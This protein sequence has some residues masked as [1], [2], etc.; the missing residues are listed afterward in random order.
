MLMKVY[1]FT[2]T[3]PPVLTDPSNIAAGSRACPIET[4]HAY[5]P[6]DNNISTNNTPMFVWSAV[7]NTTVYELEVSTS[8]L[9]ASLVEGYP[10]D[11][12]GI[13][14]TTPTLPD[15][16]YYW[17]VR[18][19]TPPDGAFT[20]TR[21]FTVRPPQMPSVNINTQA[22]SFSLSWSEITEADGYVIE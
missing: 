1:G 17:R 5:L 4:F 16:I 15:G 11:V 22:A 18:A 20:A 6:F 13:Q 7:E 21:T 9:F 2:S 8:A 19:K 14:Y 3:N 12:N 10:Q